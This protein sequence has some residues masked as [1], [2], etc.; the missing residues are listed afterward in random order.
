[1]KRSPLQLIQESAV[2]ILTP[3]DSKTLY[4][5]CVR[6]AISTAGA[7][8]GSI[9]ISKNDRLIRQFSTVPRITRLNPRPDGDTYQAFLNGETRVINAAKIKINHPEA[10]RTPDMIMILPLSY[11]TKRI[12]V[13]TLHYYDRPESLVEIKR[14]LKVF[15]ALASLAIR[16][17]D[18]YERS[19]RALQTRE[20][21]MSMAAHEFKTPLAVIQAYAQI[22]AKKLKQE[23]PVQEKWIEAILSNGSR[24][25][26]LVQELF[27]LSQIRMGVF[28]YNFCQM[29]LRELVVKNVAD[30]SVIHKRQITFRDLLRTEENTIDGDPEKLT[31]VLSN[32]IG[33]AVKFSEIDTPITITL[34][35]G[36]ES[37][38]LSV[39]DRGRGI[40]PEDLSRIFEQFYQGGEQRAVGMGLGMYLCKEI[41]E[42][43]QGEIK[44]TSRL[45]SGTKVLIRLPL[46][47]YAQI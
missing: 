1:M 9:F 30:L 35:R 33:N 18:L 44:V 45:G 8:Y 14:T 34:K 27:S 13:I 4:R 40:S 37:Y 10:V 41:I 5:V 28:T 16:N 21:F 23:R 24:L 15:A 3:L 17:V 43:H 7:K 6:E 47:S 38:I 32:L 36:R 26:S 20:L 39:E 46:A 19:R 11:Q 31:Q 2:K 22:A 42:A 12:G 25:Q 29:D